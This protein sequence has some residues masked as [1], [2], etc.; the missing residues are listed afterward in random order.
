[1]SGRYVASLYSRERMLII[2]SLYEP[3]SHIFEAMPKT[4]HFASRKS[5]LGQP[6][7]TNFNFSTKTVQV[8]ISIALATRAILHQLRYIHQGRFRIHFQHIFNIA[9]L[10]ESTFKSFKKWWRCR[11][12]AQ[13]LRLHPPF[14]PSRL[15]I[16]TKIHY[17]KLA[18]HKQ[19]LR[20]F[21]KQ[22]DVDFKEEPF[23]GEKEQY[24]EEE[25]ETKTKNKNWQM[26]VSRGTKMPAKSI[27]P[28]AILPPIHTTTILTAAKTT[29]TTSTNKPRTIV[30][31]VTVIVRSIIMDLTMMGTI[32]SIQ[33]F[34]LVFLVTIYLHLLWIWI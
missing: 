4:S 31:T 34:A 10:P 23:F 33:H 9:S 24:P 19:R 3:M 26:R 7:S 16:I 17:S 18:N 11:G 1:M 6:L 20:A 32:I 29:A 13:C 2:F 21:R 5:G 8:N 22:P 12:V 14:S 25:L 28:R 15:P 30:A 27:M